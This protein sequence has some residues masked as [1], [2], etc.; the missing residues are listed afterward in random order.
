MRA[1]SEPRRPEFRSRAAF[2]GLVIA[3][4][5]ALPVV[6]HAAGPQSPVPATEPTDTHEAEAPPVQADAAPVH[7]ERVRKHER[8]GMVR[9]DRPVYRNGVRVLWHGAWRATGLTAGE[10]APAVPARTPQSRRSPTSSF[11]PIAADDLCAAAWRANSRA[12]C[13]A[14]ACT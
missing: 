2:R 6:T 12:R 4:T 11:S 13:K 14:P 1:V 9:Y 3:A 5:L 10:A 8:F 7:T